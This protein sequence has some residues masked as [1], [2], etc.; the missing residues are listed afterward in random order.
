DDPSRRVTIATTRPETMLADVA[1]AVN[2]DDERY[3]ALVGKTVR[4]PIVD[5][6]IP[7]IA[8]DYADPEFGTGVVKITP[9]HDANDFDVGKRHNLAAPMVINEHGAMAEETDA[10]GRVPAF[11]RGDDRFVARKKIVKALQESGALVKTE[12]HQHAVRHCYRCDTV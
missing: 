10:E 12:Q 7:I 4:L 8:D 1:V 6:D 2:P 5:I 9:A 11:L 3:R